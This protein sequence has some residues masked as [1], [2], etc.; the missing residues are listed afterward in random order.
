MRED[1]FYRLNVLYLQLP[2]LRERQADIPLLCRQFIPATK[3]PSLSEVLNEMM[4]TL[5]LY[6]WPGNVREL[7][8]FCQRLLFYKEKFLLNKDVHTLLR[9]VAPNMVPAEQ[10]TA[11]SPATLNAKV[12]AYESTLL[13]EAVK[14]A[15]SIR[16][17]AQKLGIGK[18][19]LA[20]KLKDFP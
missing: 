2:S 17:A 6:P 14:E 18:S 5:L 15:G 12:A 9:Q 8:N 1:L 3:L 11:L 10:A 19:T 20:R 4:P 16:K 7:Q 13:K